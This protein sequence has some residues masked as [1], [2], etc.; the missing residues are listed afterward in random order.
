MYDVEEPKGINKIIWTVQNFIKQSERVLNV[1][2]KPKREEFQRIALSTGLGM[3]VIG[4]IAYV[5]SMVSYWLKG[6]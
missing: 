1:T 5:I 4:I 3:T 2:H 6:S